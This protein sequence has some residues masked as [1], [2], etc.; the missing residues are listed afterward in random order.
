MM[1][2]PSGL[3]RGLGALFG[4]NAFL[5]DDEPDTNR[6]GGVMTSWL[7]PNSTP[8]SFSSRPTADRISFRDL[9][10]TIHFTS[11]AAQSLLR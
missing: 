1:K 3:G 4:D 9:A 2:K 10:R 6:N 7:S 5:A 8:R 11:S